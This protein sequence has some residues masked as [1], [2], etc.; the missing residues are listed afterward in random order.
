[1]ATRRKAILKETCE[2][3]IDERFEE[4]IME[5]RARNLSP[6]T[7]TCYKESFDKF[8]KVIDKNMYVNDLTNKDIVEFA[9]SLLDEEIAESSINH[10]LRDIKAFVNWC[11]KNEYIEKGFKIELIRHQETQ[12]DPYTDEEIMRLLEPPKSKTNFVELRT[13]TIIQWIIATGNRISTV[14]NIKNSDINFHRKTITLAHTKN[15]KLQE[16]PLSDSLARAIK[17]YQ[18]KTANMG[19]RSEYLFFNIYGE[20]L[21]PNAIKQSLRDY[22]LAR[23]V[24]KT[25]AHLLRHTFAK[26]YISQGGDCMTLQNILGHS[27]ITMT[28]RYVNLCTED[29]QKNYE[30]YSL[31]DRVSSPNTGKKRHTKLAS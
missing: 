1:M 24:N 3:T 20:Q 23:G 28:R 5:K 29:L 4:Y 31:L 15:K 12:K 13:Y 11:I 10:Y 6:K 7:I 8:S 30:N 18:K 27:S 22:N 21:T 19:I 16:I 14:I 2:Y 9:T 26:N 25:S 17:S